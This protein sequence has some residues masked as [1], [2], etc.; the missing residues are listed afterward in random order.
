MASESSSL[1]IQ[2]FNQYGILIIGANIGLAFIGAAMAKKR[3]YSYGGFLCL[4]IFATFVVGIIVAACLTPKEGSD[5][6]GKKSE[7]ETLSGIACTQCGAVCA[8]DMVHCF[9]CGRK[10]RGVC[11]SCGSEFTD[12]M[13]YCPTCGKEVSEGL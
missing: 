11:Q 3:G 4:G 8:P 1:F 2:I 7:N 12:G 6:Y 10:I 13:E 5:F 9:K